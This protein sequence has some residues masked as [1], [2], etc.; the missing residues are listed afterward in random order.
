M[1]M[2]KLL[3]LTYWIFQK[4]NLDEV[5]QKIEDIQKKLDEAKASKFQK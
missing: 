2:V 4:K 1:I 5:E 3:I